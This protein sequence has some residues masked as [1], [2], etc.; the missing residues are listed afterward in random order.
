MLFY[1]IK[2]TSRQKLTSLPQYPNAMKILVPGEQVEIVIAHQMNKQLD[3]HS[4]VHQGQFLRIEIPD[5][6]KPELLVFA[7]YKYKMNNSNELK[8][9]I[10]SA[11]CKLFNMNVEILSMQEMTAPD[12]YF[13][14]LKI[15]DRRD[16]RSKRIHT[17]DEI[18]DLDYIEE[19][20]NSYAE[21]IYPVISKEEIIK[22]AQLLMPD[23]SLMD[24][25]YRILNQDKGRFYG[26]PVQYM[27]TAASSK[28]AQDIVEVLVQALEYSHR[29]LSG[30]TSYVKTWQFQDNLSTEDIRIMIGNNYGAVTVLEFSGVEDEDDCIAPCNH[31]LTEEILKALKE[32]K[33][34]SQ[35]IFVEIVGQQQGIKEFHK[36]IRKGVTLVNI[37]EG[38]GSKEEAEVV[39]RDIIAKA[40]LGKYISF[41]DAK[42][43]IFTDTDLCYNL[44]LLYK[45]WDAYEAKALIDGIY[46]QYKPLMAARIE[47][48]E[49]DEDEDSPLVRFSNMIGLKEIKKTAM[50]IIATFKIQKVR[51]SLGLD[52]MSFS[53]HML[54]TGNPGTAKTTVA[55][56]M[57]Q[58]FAKEGITS[59]ATFIECGR[60][61]LVGQYV[62]QTALKVKK[63]FEQAKGGVL[64][65]D[66][67]YSLLDGYRG[68]Y[69]DEAIATIVQEM[70]NNRKDTIVI[71]AGYPDQM[72]KFLDIN[73]GL[74][75]RIGFHL[76]FPDYGADDLLAILELMLKEREYSLTSDAKMQILTV[77]KEAVKQVEFGNGR[78]VRN[79]LEQMIMQ[80]SFR[81]FSEGNVKEWDK[82]SI[83]LLTA[84]DV[85]TNM[86]TITKTQDNSIGFRCA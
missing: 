56:L 30:R 59:T 43:A 78:F 4:K 42:K 37:K 13:Q 52:K 22:K 64:F 11:F 79:L 73:E 76:D 21:K 18:I 28:A 63:V 26:I 15:E 81:L 57:A 47:K 31:G 69:G 83:S 61:D 46:T 36:A 65:I 40:E 9:Y 74:R 23:S 34:Y 85:P 53:R 25:I 19:R 49:K 41:E 8:A 60:S 3:E 80:Q 86:V 5:I 62:G 35:L 39:L 45:R 51:E 77:F 68:Y 20:N 55:R 14:V 38:G 54:F 27:I 67:A 17:S 16:D 50:K 6:N 29:I 44:S 66:E 10:V 75:S 24:E 71:F 48:V 2:I 12:F 72:A 82:E 70:E 84:A 33:K 32:Y 7:C 1:E 58:I